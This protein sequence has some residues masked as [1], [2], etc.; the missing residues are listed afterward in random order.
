[1]KTSHVTGCVQVN[2]RLNN[3]NTTDNRSQAWFTIK[4]ISKSHALIN[5]ESRSH[6]TF[7]P[8]VYS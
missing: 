6:F 8:S 3:E 4:T 7:H 5:R 1:M 2:S